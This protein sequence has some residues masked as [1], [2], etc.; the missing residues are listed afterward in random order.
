MR[1]RSMAAE[2]VFSVPDLKRELL[3]LVIIDAA[4]TNSHAKR[5]ATTKRGSTPGKWRRV[6]AERGFRSAGDVKTRGPGCGRK[7]C[8]AASRHS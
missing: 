4:G 8:Y 3:C 5:E 7:R 6:D 2:F 1:T